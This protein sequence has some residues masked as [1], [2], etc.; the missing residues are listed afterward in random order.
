MKRKILIFIA[1]IAIYGINAFGQTKQESISTLVTPKQDAEPATSPVGMPSMCVPLCINP[2]PV[3][4]ESGVLGT[5]YVSGVASGLVQLQ[6]SI[7]PGD[8]GHQSD[9]SNAQIFIQKTE[10]LVQFFVQVGAY[11]LPDLGLPYIPSGL[12]T[13]AFYGVFPQGYLKLAPTKNF[14]IQ[15][16]KL[17]TLIGAEYTFSFENTNIQRGLLWNQENAVNRGVQ[18]NYTAGPLNLSLSYNDG[19]YSNKYNWVTGSLAYTVNKSNSIAFIGG[20][21]TSRTAISTSATPLYQNNEQLYNLIYT[22]TSGQWT[23]QPYLQYTF[24]PQSS[25]LKT[26]QD[27]ST[28]GAALLCN[29]T[30]AKSGFSLP[31]RLEYITST[32]SADKGAPSLIYGPGSKAWSVTLS[33]TYQYKR[34]FARAELSYV[35]ANDIT[36]GSAMGPLGNDAT[37]SRA[38]LEIGILF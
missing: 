21:S 31:F 32:G 8:Y 2:D 3:K 9:V 12:A 28:Y 24:V 7:F 22:R 33:P 37:Q 1:F 15:A 23:I 27:A 34:L 17:P 14:S 25:L 38:L 10:G 6:N 26:T 5:I 4:M 16:G 11:S 29:Y 18:L 30:V 19:M 20:G 35:Q 13:N 36:K